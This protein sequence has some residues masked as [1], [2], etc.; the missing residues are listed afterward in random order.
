MEPRKSKSTSDL[1]QGNIDRRDFLKRMGG[2]VG[3]AAAAGALLPLMENTSA[4]AQIFPKDDSRLI[5]EYLKYSGP[6]G[7]IR[8]YSAKPKKEGKLPAV[9]VIHENRGLVPHI[10]EVSRRLA[11][12]GF[13]AVAPDA[14]TP[15]G[16]TPE[17]Q[18]KGP[19]MIQ[20]L[21]LAA[22]VQNYLAAVKF[23]KTHPV[24]SGKVGV[25]GFCWGGAM[26][27]QMAVHSPD[28]TA[29]VPY[30]GRP[31]ASEDV[32]KIKI[33][34]LLH[35][36][37]TDPFINPAIPAFEEALKKA[38]VNYKLYMYPGAQH[39]FNNDTNP[40][41]YNKEA[42]ELAWGRTIAF[43]KEKLK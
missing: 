1:S 11:L 32:P 38:A 6:A 29:A 15:L 2:L 25:V 40:V 7:E 33:P 3:G 39:A 30:Y 35:Y 28:L 37:G 34:L 18:E 26:A 5:T 14:L 19:A 36:A 22:T 21:D 42:A 23:L 43:F 20:K 9:L 4:L 17:N 8:A 41:R 27:N 31:P 16:G 13:W 10:E 12:E 24:S